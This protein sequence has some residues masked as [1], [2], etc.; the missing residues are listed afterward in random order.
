MVKY[1]VKERANKNDEK[2]VV[3]E[4]VEEEEEEVVGQEGNH[5]EQKVENMQVN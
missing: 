4:V 5:D 2:V 1:Q 3:E